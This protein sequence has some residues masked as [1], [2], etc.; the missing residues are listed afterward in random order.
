VLY[1]RV[2]GRTEDDAEIAFLLAEMF[3]DPRDPGWVKDK[4][5]FR[6]KSAVDPA[7]TPGGL[8][9]IGRYLERQPIAL[10]PLWG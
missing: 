10:V 8:A 6:G 4:K 9:R 5:R 3:Q 2:A 7:R 1:G